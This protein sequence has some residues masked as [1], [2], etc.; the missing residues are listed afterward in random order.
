MVAVLRRDGHVGSVEEEGENGSVA[1]WQS[2]NSTP[3]DSPQQSRRQP[4]RSSEYADSDRDTDTGN[5]ESDT[6]RD[7]GNTEGDTDVMLLYC[8]VL[9]LCLFELCLCRI[10][11]VCV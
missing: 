3:S 1:S 11:I 5:T 6:D 10:Y 7:T 2:I 9:K 4:P 8:S